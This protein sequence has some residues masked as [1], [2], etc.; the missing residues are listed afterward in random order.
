[1]IG[2]PCG[3]INEVDEILND[4]HILA[5]G[6]VV[7]MEHP[8]AGDIR[9]LG[10]PMHL[11]ATPPTYRLPPPTLGQH[12]DDILWELGYSAEEIAAMREDGVI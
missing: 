1:A 8:T 10:N 2:I 5:R 4:P 7:E 11:S 9:V 3:A 12:T 6:M